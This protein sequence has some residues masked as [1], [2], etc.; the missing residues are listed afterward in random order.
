MCQRYPRPRGWHACAGKRR[1]VRPSPLALVLRWRDALR[2]AGHSIRDRALGAGSPTSQLEQHMNLVD[3]TTTLSSTTF[4]YGFGD[5]APAAGAFRPL[6]DIKYDYHQDPDA[7]ARE[8]AASLRQA[9]PPDLGELRGFM[10]YWEILPDR[11]EGET[12]ASYRD[13]LVHELEMFAIRIG[14][15]RAEPVIAANELLVALRDHLT[16]RPGEPLPYLGWYGEF[17]KYAGIPIPSQVGD[18]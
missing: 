5:M 7:Y 12:D 8:A 18:G 16:T 3:G 13:R 15:Y 17:M 9:F 2:N 4:A 6:A 1:G 14:Y 11:G 10:T